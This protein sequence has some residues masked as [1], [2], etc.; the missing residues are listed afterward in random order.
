M[1]MKYW[2][3]N[4]KPPYPALENDDYFLSGVCWL[5]IE[6]KNRKIDFWNSNLYFEVKYSGGGKAI[7]SV[8]DYLIHHKNMGSHVFNYLIEYDEPFT[9]S[10]QFQDDMDVS[11]I[12]VKTEKFQNEEMMN[13]E[14]SLHE[15]AKLTTESLSKQRPLT[16]DEMRAQTKKV[17]RK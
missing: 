10:I 5:I 2:E 12:T 6:D 17:N 9:I 16:L 15:L 13:P 14:I 3:Q 7:G 11:G 4:I 8:K 1:K